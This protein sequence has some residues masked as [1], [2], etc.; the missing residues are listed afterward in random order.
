MEYIATIASL[1]Y[2]REGK[3]IFD[4]DTAICLY[5]IALLEIERDT[6]TNLERRRTLLKEVGR[7]LDNRWKLKGEENN[8]YAADEAD[9]ER[10]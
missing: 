10:A 7:L 9:I 1:P 6:L 4:L 5:T 8:G 2:R 3:K